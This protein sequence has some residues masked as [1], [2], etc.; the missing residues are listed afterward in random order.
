MANYFPDGSLVEELDDLKTNKYNGAELCA[1]VSNHTPVHGD[2]AATYTAIEAT[3]G[4]YSRITLNSWSAAYV[5]ASLEAQIDEAVRTWTATGSGLPQTIYGIFILSAGG[6]LLY[7][8]LNP[9]GGVTL[10]AAGHSFPYTPK[11]THKRG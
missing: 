9:T 8:E 5:N 10:S 7:V 3:F 6:T 2:V 1:F 11:R 4:G